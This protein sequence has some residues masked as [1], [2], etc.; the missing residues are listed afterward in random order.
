MVG[1]EA[2]RF[3]NRDAYPQPTAEDRVKAPPGEVVIY[4]LR[5]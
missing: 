2:V 5:I 1:H 3:Q 4:L